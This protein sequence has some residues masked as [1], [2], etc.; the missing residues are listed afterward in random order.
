MKSARS[1]VTPLANH[2]LS[3]RRPH[4]PLASSSSTALLLA[5]YYRPDTLRQVRDVLVAALGAQLLQR[6][7]QAQQV[8]PVQPARTLGPVDVLGQGLDVLGADELVVIWGPDVCDVSKTSAAEPAV[9]NFWKIIH[10]HWWE[11]QSRRR[12]IRT[13]KGPDGLFWI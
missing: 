12:T 3:S 2:V 5:R 11:P 9:M 8:V 6:L 13:D 1:R 4:A 10:G 7:V